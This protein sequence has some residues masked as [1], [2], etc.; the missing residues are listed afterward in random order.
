METTNTQSI[1]RD[2]RTKLNE[3][4]AYEDGWLYG[5]GTKY[6]ANQ[7]DWLAEKLETF[8]PKQIGLTLI[9]PLV[10]NKVCLEWRFDRISQS[11]EISLTEGTAYLYWINL[12]TKKDLDFDFVIST[13]QGWVE[14][15]KQLLILGK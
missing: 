12:A 14:M 13:D 8:L 6:D 11:V 2:I 9:F 1:N 5:Y 10:G 4:K 7:L 3:F 15:Q